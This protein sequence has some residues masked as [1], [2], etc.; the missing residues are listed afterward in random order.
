MLWN[1]VKEAGLD[2]L[3]TT[4]MNM[5]MT[6]ISKFNLAVKFCLFSEFQV[7]GGHDELWG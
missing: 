7:D 1:D 4:F 2:A 5:V 3:D 6:K